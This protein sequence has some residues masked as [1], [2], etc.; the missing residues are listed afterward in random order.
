MLPALTRYARLHVG[1]DDVR[2]VGYT[3]ATRG[4]KHLCRHCP[5]VPIYGGRFRVVPVDVVIADVRQQVEAGAS[6]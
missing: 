3:E 5:I 6:T 1:T 2:T 4:C